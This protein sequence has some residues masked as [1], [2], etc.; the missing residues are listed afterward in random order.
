[1]IMKIVKR[2]GRIANFDLAKIEQAIYKHQYS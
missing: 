1:M 2:D